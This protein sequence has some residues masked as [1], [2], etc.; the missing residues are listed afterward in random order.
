[1]IHVLARISASVVISY[2]SS[3]V[4][5]FGFVGLYV[6][7]LIVT[8][9]LCFKLNPGIFFK[10]KLSMYDKIILYLVVLQYTRLV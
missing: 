7:A 3:H 6:L 2:V 8:Q 5:Y 1:M 4:K 9:M 10:Y